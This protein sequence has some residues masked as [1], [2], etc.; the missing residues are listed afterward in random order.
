MKRRTGLLSTRSWMRSW[1]LEDMPTSSSDILSEVKAVEED[2]AVVRTTDAAAA[3][4]GEK[5]EAHDEED[6]RAAAKMMGRIMVKWVAGPS[7]QQSRRQ[8]LCLLGNVWVQWAMGKG[9]L[10]P[11]VYR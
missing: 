6:R 2:A 5:A 4:A 11:A 10:R 9:G 8:E 1:V 7:I 3:A